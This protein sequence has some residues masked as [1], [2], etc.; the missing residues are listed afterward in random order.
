M[1]ALTHREQSYV[2]TVRPPDDE[3]YTAL[4]SALSPDLACN[5]VRKSLGKTRGARSELSAIRFCTHEHRTYITTK[6]DRNRNLRVRVYSCDDCYEEICLI[7][8]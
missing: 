6:R 7:P 1:Y 4:V 5:K 3:E 2:V 8:A